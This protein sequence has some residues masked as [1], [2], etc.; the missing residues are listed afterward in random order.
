MNAEKRGKTRKKR[1]IL[2]SLREKN[3]ATNDTNRL[4]ELRRVKMNTNWKNELVAS[5]WE[6]TYIRVKCIAAGRNFPIAPS[7]RS[8]CLPEIANA[9]LALSDPGGA[10]RVSLQN[11]KFYR[12]KYIY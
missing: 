6:T 11:R 10:S 5:R 12:C 8:V 3:R 7:V 2:W 9:E 1:K 4:R